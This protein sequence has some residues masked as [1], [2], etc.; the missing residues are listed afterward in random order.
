MQAQNMPI[1]VQPE[2]PRH[3]QE[4]DRGHESAP[5]E[6]QKTHNICA[7]TLQTHLIGVPNSQQ[8]NTAIA[9][10]I[11]TGGFSGSLSDADIQRIVVAVIAALHAT[12]IPT[13]VRKVNGDTIIGHGIPPTYDNTGT[14][15][16]PGDPWRP[17]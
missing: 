7:S 15:T 12:A 16:D 17:Q 3:A 10:A 8:I 11:S 4:K 9:A 5:D 2:T 1:L 13:D 6:R 14:L